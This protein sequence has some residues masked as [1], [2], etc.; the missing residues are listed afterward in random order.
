MPYIYSMAGKVYCQD[1]TMMRSLLFDF[2]EDS[3]AKNIETEY[4]F[5]ESLLVC[6]V[7]EPM[8]FEKGSR[9]LQRS[10]GWECYLPMGTDWYDFYTGEKYSGGGT[11]L[12]ETALDRIPL[13]VRAGA[14]LI[15]EKEL[16]YAGQQT[17]EPL[18]I[19][20]YP[21]YDGTYAYYEDAGHGYGYENGDYQIVEFR[22]ED[23]AG[24]LT[25]GAAHKI[26]PQG[27]V[28]RELLIC[29]GDRKQCVKYEGDEVTVAFS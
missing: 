6:P 24:C 2:P 16:M 17:A 4:M 14:I 1:Y 11:V 3:H 15:M 26:Y 7:T 29:L 21:G 22:W 12:V 28:G 23:F 13:F 9:E 18:E 10:K 27:I 20:I 25:I 8:Y 19:R 5:G